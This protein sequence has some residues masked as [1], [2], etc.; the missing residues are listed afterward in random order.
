LENVSIRNRGAATSAVGISIAQPTNTASLTNVTIDGGS[1]VG[2]GTGHLGLNMLTADVTVDG[3]T[4]RNFITGLNVSAGIEATGLTLIDN[5]TGMTANGQVILNDLYIRGGYQGIV[6]GGQGTVVTINGGE[7]HGTTGTAANGHGIW[8]QRPTGTAESILNLNDVEIHNNE[9]AGVGFQNA[10][11]SIGMVL[12]VNA[13]TVIHNNLD[14]IALNGAT[15]HVSG[16]SNTVNINGGVIRDNNRAGIRGSAMLVPGANE[17]PINNHIINILAAEISGNAV[18]GIQIVHENVNVNVVEATISD[19]GAAAL[20]GGG[21]SH[22]NMENVYV[23]EAVVFQRNTATNGILVDDAL[24]ATFAAVIRPGTTSFGTHAFNNI[25]IATPN[26]TL[27]RGFTVDGVAATREANR[28]WVVAFPVGTDV[29]DFTEADFIVDAFASYT[30]TAINAA[31]GIWQITVELLDN[32]PYVVNV[33]LQ[34]DCDDASITALTVLG[35][36][37]TFDDVEDTWVVQL[38][39]GTDLAGLTATDFNVTA[40][41]RATYEITALNAAQGEWVIT[42]TAQ[43]GNY[44]RHY[45]LI[46]VAPS[47]DATMAGFTLRGIAAELVDDNDWTVTFPAP[48]ATDE[49]EYVG[50][51]PPDRIVFQGEVPMGITSDQF[52]VDIAEGATVTIEV[53]DLAAGTWTIDITAEDGI[54][55]VRHNVRIIVPNASPQRTR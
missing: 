10:L 8:L 15:H 54:T 47:S 5:A 24:A 17:N 20:N 27:L 55:T 19:N 37:A 40:H 51:T 1:R 53:V 35:E 31:G 9:Q 2:G 38:P 22:V 7:I 48:S 6:T 44:I 3:L 32:P 23:A 11:S 52:V 12:N 30:I 26:G 50:S 49:R 39:H 41:S 14:G 42:V 43:L 45:V 36:P 33:A 29:S 16:Y 21:L 28:N 46:T 34:S 25:D 13:G 4:I 18:S